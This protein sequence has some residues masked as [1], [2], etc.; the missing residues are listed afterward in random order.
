MRKQQQQHNGLCHPNYATLDLLIVV[1][2]SMRPC[3]YLLIL[4]LIAVK[5][6]KAGP[7]PLYRLLV[8]FVYL[9]VYLFL[10]LFVYV[11]MLVNKIQ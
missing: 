1:V 10:S 3:I 6:E 2:R 11:V 5:T 9:F 4:S 7:H 8:L